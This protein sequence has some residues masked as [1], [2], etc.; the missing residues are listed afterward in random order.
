M[1]YFEHHLFIISS[2]NPVVHVIPSSFVC[3]PLTWA[4]AHVTAEFTLTARMSGVPASAFAVFAAAVA[5]ACMYD[6]V[7]TVVPRTPCATSSVS[8]A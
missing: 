5:V 7:A 6:A 8:M 1:T 2:Q 4:L 3:V